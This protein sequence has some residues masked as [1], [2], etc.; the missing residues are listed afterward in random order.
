M[1]AAIALIEMHTKRGCMATRDGVEDLDLLPGQRSS[2]AL[3]KSTAAPLNDIGH[4]PGWA[5]HHSLSL[6]KSRIEI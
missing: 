6:A 4:L 2:I 1:L 3:Q 5:C